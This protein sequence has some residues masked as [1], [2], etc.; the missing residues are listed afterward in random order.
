MTKSRTPLRLLAPLL[1]CWTEA[2]STQP[3]PPA[4]AEELLAAYN[5]RIH[6][7]MGSV[8]GRR[9]CPREAEGEDAIVV[10]GHSSDSLMRLPLR[11]GPEAGARH[12]LIAGEAPLARD[13][14]DPDRCLRLCYQPVTI[15]IIPA[16]RALGSGLDRLLHPN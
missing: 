13:A 4:S 2:A 14:M 1:F 10:C 3:D 6:D 16:I 15:P 5:A 9:R 8:D 7:A 11:V 12:R